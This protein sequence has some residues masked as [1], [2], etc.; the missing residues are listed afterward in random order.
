MLVENVT[1]HDHHPES[2]EILPS[3]TL[4][5]D[6]VVANTLLRTEEMFMGVPLSVVFSSKNACVCLSPRKTRVF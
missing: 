4:Q 5:Q 6:K 2:N 3:S 1:Q